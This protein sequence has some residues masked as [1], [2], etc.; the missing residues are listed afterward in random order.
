MGPYEVG[1]LPKIRHMTR[2]TLE[3]AALLAAALVFGGCAVTVVDA[4]TGTTTTGQG[5]AGS[6]SSSVGQG[7][8][9]GAAS[10]CAN[11][12]ATSCSCSE[13]TLRIACSPKNGKIECVC[14]YG[15]D[16]SGI[17]FEKDPALLCNFEKGCCANYFTGQ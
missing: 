8:A 12:D 3:F 14:S 16:F 5:G 4:G 7:G 9:G 17:C 1:H 10:V 6:S 11:H 15:S 2:T 13:G